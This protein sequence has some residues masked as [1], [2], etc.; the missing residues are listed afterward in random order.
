MHPG[1]YTASKSQTACLRCQS[2]TYADPPPAVGVTS[3]SRMTAVVLI[4]EPC[5]QRALLGDFRFST[6]RVQSGQSLA[7]SAHV[8]AS[9]QLKAHL[10]ARVSRYHSAKLTSSNSVPERRVRTECR[11]QRLHPMLSGLHPAAPSERQ[12]VPDVLNCPETV[13]SVPCATGMFHSGEGASQCVACES[14]KYANDTGLSQCPMLSGVWS[15]VLRLR[16]RQG[17]ILR[18]LRRYWRKQLRRMFKRYLLRYRQF[19][20]RHARF[21]NAHNSAGVQVVPSRR[22]SAAQR[23]VGLVRLC[24]VLHV[25]PCAA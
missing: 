19:T 14:G 11:K 8:V 10:L 20:G 7:I 15:C 23:T 12:L 21:M 24:V 1:S 3:C 5:G 4:A 6:T 16:M 25:T 2:G 22:T 18:S 9:L 17:Q 13:C